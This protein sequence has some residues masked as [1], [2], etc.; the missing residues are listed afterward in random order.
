MNDPKFMTSGPKSFDKAAKVMNFAF[1]WCYIDSKH[2]AYQLTGWYPQRAPGT[3]PDFPILGTGQF[4]WKGFDPDHAHGRLAAAVASTRTRST[5]ATSSPG[6][7]SRRRA[8]RPPT[9]S[10]PTARSTARR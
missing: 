4:D 9:T 6:T 5:R 2:I 3:S 10:T 1:N 7:T 8:G